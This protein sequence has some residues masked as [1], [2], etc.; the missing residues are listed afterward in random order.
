[1]SI[2]LGVYNISE[3]VVPGLAPILLFFNLFFVFKNDIVTLSILF[4]AAGR[5]YPVIAPGHAPPLSTKIDSP[6]ARGW[7]LDVQPCRR[8]RLYSSECG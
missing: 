3:P 2:T 7:A 8:R 1:M 4:L 5:A 6:I